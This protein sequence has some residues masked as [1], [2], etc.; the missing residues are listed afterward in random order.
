MTVTELIAVLQALPPTARVV[1][2]HFDSGFDDVVRVHRLPIKVGTSHIGSGAHD[3]PDMFSETSFE[4]DETAVVLDI[5]GD[6]HG[7]R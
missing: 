2:P 1:V 7:A 3:G 5:E 4:P 6:G